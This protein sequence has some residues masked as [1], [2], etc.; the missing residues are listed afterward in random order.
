MSTIFLLNFM[1][2]LENMLKLYY[3]LCNYSEPQWR[4]EFVN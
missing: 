1:K 4:F 3:N 2:L